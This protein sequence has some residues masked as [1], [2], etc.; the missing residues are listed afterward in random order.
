MTGIKGILHDYQY[1]FFIISRSVLLGMKNVSDK[2]CRENLNVY[3]MF[4]NFFF[5]KIIL[6][7][8]LT[9]LTWR[10]CELIIPANGRWDLT[11]LL[12]G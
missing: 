6:S 3:F 7:V 1:T 8:T 9:L 11:W 12:K 10:I 5:S 4:N 2:S